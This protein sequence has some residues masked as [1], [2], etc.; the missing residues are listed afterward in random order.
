MAVESLP[1]FLGQATSRHD[2]VEP[3]GAK[4]TYHENHFAAG[5]VRV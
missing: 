3:F 4:A 2:L 1:W 5:K